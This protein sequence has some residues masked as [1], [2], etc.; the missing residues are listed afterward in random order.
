MVQSMSFSSPLFTYLFTCYFVT[1]N[2]LESDP[3]VYENFCQIK[4]SPALFEKIPSLVCLV[5]KIENK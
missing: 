3:H 5:F 4:F 2:L 1:K